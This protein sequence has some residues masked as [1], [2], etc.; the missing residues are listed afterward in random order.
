MEKENKYY[1]IIENL[2]RT[3]KKFPGL[4]AILED[5]IEDVYSHSE[6]ILNTVSNDAVLNA[7]LSKVVST[8]MITVP[9]RMNFHSELNHRVITNEPVQTEKPYTKVDN[10]LV[11][12]M[13]NSTEKEE[14]KVIEPEVI[15]TVEPEIIEEVKEEFLIETPA[16]EKE[17]ESFIEE[18]N[19]DEFE[20]EEELTP[21]LTFEE[22]DNI[23]EHEPELAVDESE[24]TLETEIESELTVDEVE[25]QEEMLE[26]PEAL[27]EEV[28]EDLEIEEPEILPEETTEDLE[29]EEP[30]DIL[31][32]EED[33]LPEADT[34]TVLDETSLDEPEILEEEIT[35]LSEE[36]EELLVEDNTLDSLD[37]DNLEPEDDSLPEEEAV[38]L[39]LH[40][41]E[42]EEEEVI[43]FTSTDYSKFEFTPENTEPDESIDLELISKD[44]QELDSKHPELNIIEI[45]N[46]KYKDSLSVSEISSQLD[47][48]EDKVIEALNEIIAVL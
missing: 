41:E 2:I 5:I 12:K 3:H 6:V 33:L 13:I 7:Y 16:P 11:D 32:P 20:V 18:I 19:L 4:E 10:N 22:V 25:Q 27:Q 30:Q 28:L 1:G 26:E 17:A 46:L 23:V 15:E 9:K 14:V 24:N 48:S 37:F 40:E 21:E 45:Y 35:E 38:E 31:L 34:E 42:E 36:P 39:D 43:N 47:M 29:I 44:L 8:S